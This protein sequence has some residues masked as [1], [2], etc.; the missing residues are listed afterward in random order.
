M[1]FVIFFTAALV[2]I[3]VYAYYLSVRG[4]K[5]GRAA[6]VA[7]FA[8]VSA[9]GLLPG[10]RPGG[11]PVALLGPP[12]A[13]V[14]A[15]AAGRYGAARPEAAARRLPAAF[16]ITLLAAVLLSLNAHNTSGSMFLSPDGVHYWLI[17]L[18][19]GIPLTAMY[20]ADIAGVD[21]A[22]AYRAVEPFLGMPVLVSKNFLALVI[23]FSACG[24]FFAYSLLRSRL[25]GGLLPELDADAVYKP[26]K[27]SVYALAACVVAGA[28]AEGP[29][30]TAARQAGAGLALMFAASGLYCMLRLYYRNLPAAGHVVVC[31]MAAGTVLAPGAMYAVSAVGLAFRVFGL[32]SMVPGYTSPAPP[33]RRPPARLW[34]T[35]LV[36]AAAFVLLSPI[37]QFTD[38]YMATVNQWLAGGGPPTPTRPARPPAGSVPAVEVEGYRHV[39]YIDAYE[40]PGARGDTPLLAGSEREAEEQCTVRGGR[41]CAPGEWEY[42]CTSGGRQERIKRYEKTV[43]GRRPLCNQA[44]EELAPAGAHPDCHPDLFPGAKDMAGNAWEIVSA[45]GDIPVIV[46]KGGY[47]GYSDDYTTRCGYTLVVFEKQADMMGD[48]H[49]GFRCCY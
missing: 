12:L 5:R 42:V 43:G 15:W 48:T 30:G 19:N 25:P 6:A 40:Y 35:Y 11:M 32:Y 26:P 21:A 13:V 9:V 39:F 37:Q 44:E 17:N 29:F 49:F 23:F 22:A 31:V 24:G 46:M 34:R 1:I 27:W 38:N 3:D 20:A 45:R 2:Y 28:A 36:P 10:L 41:L 8:A 18:M 33:R 14:I 47:F 7:V 16:A 4:T